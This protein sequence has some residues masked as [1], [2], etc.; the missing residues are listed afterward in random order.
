MKDHIKKLM[1]GNGLAQAIQFSSIILLSRLYQ[2]NDF[3]VLAQVQSVAMLISIFCTLQLH[4][5]I[6]L[7]KSY[8]DACNIISGVQYLC[9]LFSALFIAFGFFIGDIYLFSAILAMFLG[10]INTYNGFYIYSGEFKSLA[11]FYIIRSILIVVTQVIFSLFSINYGLIF[12]TL[13]AEFLSASYLLYKQFQINSPMT[14]SFNNVLLIVREWKSFSL[15]GTV[16]EIIS[17]AAFYVP[18][19][20][21][22]NKF[23]EHIGG[24]YAM[25]SR[26]IW[27]PIILISSSISQVLYHSYGKI[28]PSSVRSLLASV[29]YNIFILILIFSITIWAIG[30]KVISLVLGNNWNI[31]A[32][33]IPILLIWGGV[34]ILSIPFRVFIRTNLLQKYQ[35][36]VDFCMIC[37]FLSVFYFSDFSPSAVVWALAMIAL[38]QNL[39]LVLISAWQIRMTGVERSII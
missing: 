31:T 27:A 7:Q 22:V 28:N 3:G 12:A 11:N 17:V 15:Y 33:F 30:S 9:V 25:A 39:L 6:P 10:F 1:L 37:S 34:F 29:P 14:F 13:F 4:L 21:F 35:L 18:L 32:E 24:Q 16:Q 26:L 8:E 23:G 5:V 36:F 2:P 38:V 20:L 19:F